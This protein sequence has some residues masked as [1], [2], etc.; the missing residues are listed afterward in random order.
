M[1]ATAAQNRRRVE[2]T[3]RPNRRL[4]IFAFGVAFVTRKPLRTALELDGDNV[5]CAVPVSAPCLGINLNAADR[6]A[7]N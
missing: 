3:F 6:F 7:V 4:M 2:F 1:P 5:E